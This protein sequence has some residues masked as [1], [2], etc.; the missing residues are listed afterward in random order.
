MERTQTIR[1]RRIGAAEISEI[2]RFVEEHLEHNRSWLSRELCRRWEWRQANGQL[3]EVACRELLLRLERQGCLRLPPRQREGSNDKRQGSWVSYTGKSGVFLPPGFSNDPLEGQLGDYGKAQFVLMLSRAERKFW[4]ILIERYH[5]LGH[6]PVAG[7]SLKYLIY[8]KGHVVGCLGWGAA[9]WKLTLRDA[10][11]GWE[12]C[13]MDRHLNSVVNNVRFLILPWVRV[14]YLASHVLAMG[15]A[16]VQTD[17]QRLYGTKPYLLE[18]FVD[19]ERFRGTCYRAANWVYLGQTRGMS[20]RGLTFY[21]HGQPKDVYVYPL[22]NDFRERL[23][24]G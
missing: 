16:Q 20:K 17:W 3:K 18:S 11:I 14:R 5:Y 1:G 6:R 21:V 10:Y 15:A 7:P 19:P 9:V 2:R 12:P 13:S 22:V 8:L 23:S 4:N 24:D